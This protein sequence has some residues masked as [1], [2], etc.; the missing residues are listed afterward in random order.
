MKTLIE[1]YDESPLKNVLASEMFRPERTV[2]ICPPEVGNNK[3]LQRK[4]REYFVHRGVKSELEFV[5]ASLL[6]ATQVEKRLLETVKRYP[7]CAL[8]V[9]GGTDAA[10]FAGGSLCASFPVP[11]FTYSRRNNTFYDIKNA[12]FARNLPC[13]VK[14]SVEDCFLMA[15]GSM[16]TGRVSDDVDIG[17]YMDLIDP[18]FSVYLRFRRDWPKIVGYIQRISQNKAD[19][20]TSVYAEGAY[21][22][23]GDYGRRVSA[24]EDVLT[25][26]EKVGAIYDLRILR[27]ERVAFTFRDEVIRK[28]LRDVGSLLEMYTYKACVDSGLFDDVRVSAIVDWNGEKPQKDSVT[29]ELDV[30]TTRGV[31]PFFISCKTGAVQ[32]EALNELAIL[33]DRFGSKV[34]RAAIVTCERGSG[35]ASM[36]RRAQELGIDVIDLNDLQSGAIGA[37]LKALVR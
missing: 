33:R 8:D 17:A 11:A 24:N 23:K 27:G 26:L 37:C 32:T 5:T 3:H 10:L 21:T 1:L 19:T 35:S 14:L 6:D 22:V 31:R 4:L 2:F 15:G 34:A 16:R 25:A 7:D 18:M 9:A 30:M 29:N 13:E 28:W 12:P 20:A 36:R